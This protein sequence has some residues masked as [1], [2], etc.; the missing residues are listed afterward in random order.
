LQIGKED[1]GKHSVMHYNCQSVAEDDGV[2]SG[3]E[4][5]QKMATINRT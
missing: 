5:Q 2:S 1:G 4:Y 3:N